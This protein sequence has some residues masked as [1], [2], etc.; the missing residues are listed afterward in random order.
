MVVFNT[1]TGNALHMSSE[2]SNYRILLY[3]HYTLEY[4]EDSTSTF[5]HHCDITNQK[6]E[7]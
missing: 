4:L 5:L 2:M 1:V 7:I 3:L 6:G